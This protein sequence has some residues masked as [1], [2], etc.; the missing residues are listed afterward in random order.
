MLIPITPDKRES[1][2]HFVDFDVPVGMTL[3]NFI[4][5]SFNPRD[6]QIP[7]GI[8]FACRYLFQDYGAE[9]LS[10]FSRRGHLRSSFFL[11]QP[12]SGRP[13]RWHQ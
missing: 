3:R 2:C 9:L 1:L 8:L 6:H 11:A 5:K 12:R 7:I 4:L 13:G 10:A